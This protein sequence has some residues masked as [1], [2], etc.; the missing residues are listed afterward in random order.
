MGLV[1]WIRLEDIAKK[2]DTELEELL[3]Q[4]RVP[5]SSNKHQAVFDFFPHMERELKKTGVTKESMWKEYYEKHPDGI[6]PTNPIVLSQEIFIYKL[7]E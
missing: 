3:S 5:L 2:S 4:E 7:G 1:G 6:H